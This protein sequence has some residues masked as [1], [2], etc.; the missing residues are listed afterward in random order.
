MA[1]LCGRGCSRGRGVPPALRSPAR[2]APAPLRPG[3]GLLGSGFSAGSKGDRCCWKP[4]SSAEG[5]RGVDGGAPGLAWDRQVPARAFTSSG[6]FTQ[7][8]DTQLR[9]PPTAV[10]VCPVKRLLFK[11]LLDTK[12][13]RVKSALTAR[14]IA[15][16][17]ELGT[18]ESGSLW[19]C[20]GV[21]HL[22]LFV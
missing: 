11:P 16:W 6:T 18:V 21:C 9:L 13:F 22:P 7:H 19:I 5:E 3:P 2:R 12:H 17:Q 10:R 1:S 20:P 4:R 8:G 15:S 14:G